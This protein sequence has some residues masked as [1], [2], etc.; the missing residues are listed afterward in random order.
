MKML[1]SMSFPIYLGDDFIVYTVNFYTIIGERRRNLMSYSSCAS[2]SARRPDTLISVS[3]ITGQRLNRGMQSSSN[4]E[5]GTKI[6]RP[7]LPNFSLQQS[8]L[9][10]LSPGDLI[11][12]T[13]RKSKAP[14]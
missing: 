5:P 6:F 1:M 12:I 7:I 4:I 9:F 10:L 11:I 2:D 13:V 3:H 8:I 14:H